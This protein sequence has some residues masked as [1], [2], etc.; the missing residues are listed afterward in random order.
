MGV[1]ASLATAALLASTPVPAAVAQTCAGAHTR[2]DTARETHAIR[3]LLNVERTR[4]GLVQLRG[5][6]LLQTAATGHSRD[7]VRRDYFAHTSPGGSTPVV[8]ARRDGYAA[9]HL[10]ET[11]AWGA[12][13]DGTPAGTVSRWMSSTGHRRAI[14]D[15]S[16]R[17]IG[18][19]VTHG[20]PLAHIQG[21]VTV[22]AE[23]GLR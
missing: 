12:G 17:E 21:G 7:M 6:A 2:G 15:A 3:C 9:T 20:S 11:I 19:G 8:R 1:L 4:R 18:V 5:S 10:A 16:V 14:L 13:S 23:F 22:T